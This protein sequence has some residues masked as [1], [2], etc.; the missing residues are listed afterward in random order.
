M[1]CLSQVVYLHEVVYQ[2]AAVVVVA[3]CVAATFPAMPHGVFPTVLKTPSFLELM[4][5]DGK[6]VA[7]PRSNPHLLG[8]T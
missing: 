2:H 1:V 7:F 8:A 3:M 4:S 5:L 6:V